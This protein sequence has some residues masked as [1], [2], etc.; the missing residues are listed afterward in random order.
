MNVYKIPIT[1]G[2]FFEGRGLDSGK[3]IINEAAI[4]A[5]GF[6]SAADAICQKIRFP[7]DATLFTIKGVTSDFNFS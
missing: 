6:K 7:S 4:F 1:A 5:L 2:A 3:V